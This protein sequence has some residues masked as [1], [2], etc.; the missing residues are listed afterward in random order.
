MYLNQS[1]IVVAKNE[2]IREDAYEKKTPSK[3]YRSVL[4]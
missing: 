2:A 3:H 1:P 4:M